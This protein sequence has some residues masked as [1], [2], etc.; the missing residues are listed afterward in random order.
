MEVLARKSPFIL[1]PHSIH[2][3]SRPRRAQCCLA[4]RGWRRPRLLGSEDAG[5]AAWNLH[6]LTDETWPKQTPGSRAQA[7][8][9]SDAEALPRARGM[10]WS[11]RGNCKQML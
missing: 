9:L 10:A 4:W 8:P 11:W 2:R 1:P 6:L 7:T 3:A 5:C